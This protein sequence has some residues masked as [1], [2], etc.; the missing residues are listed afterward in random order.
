MKCQIIRVMKPYA[1]EFHMFGGHLCG[2]VLIDKNHPDYDKDMMESDLDVHGGITYSMIE[3]DGF[4]HVGF[5][6]A[7]SGDYLPSIEKFTRE[8]KIP[9]LFPLP[10]GFEEYA[11]FNPTYRNI[12]FCRL[13]CEKL[14]EQLSER[15][16]NVSAQS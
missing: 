5:D 10:K 16:V 9:E 14:A 4:H 8:S 11:I 7:H 1:K 12:Q 6:C 15:M 2:Y 13:E 3:E